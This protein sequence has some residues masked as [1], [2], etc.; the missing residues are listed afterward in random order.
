[1]NNA[2]NLAKKKKLDSNKTKIMSESYVHIV[3]LDLLGSS[4]VRRSSS[5]QK[6]FVV[7]TRIPTLSWMRAPGTVNWR[8]MQ[9]S[10]D[11][12]KEWQDFS[13]KDNAITFE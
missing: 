1:M 10:M 9:K 4:R 13:N 3:K 7:T 11:Q 6:D 2:R 12:V 5:W 8:R